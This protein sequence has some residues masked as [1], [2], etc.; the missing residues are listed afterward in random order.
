M[1]LSLSLSPKGAGRDTGAHGNSEID[2]R[3]FEP[4]TFSDIAEHGVPLQAA[5]LN[6]VAVKPRY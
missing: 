1:S 4:A 6:A 5:A 2:H 3:P